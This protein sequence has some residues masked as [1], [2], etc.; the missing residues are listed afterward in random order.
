MFRGYWIAAIAFGLAFGA[1]AQEVEPPSLERNPV[2]EPRQRDSTSATENEA[3]ADV[4]QT[5]D[6]TPSLQ[7]IE[8]AIQNLITDVDQIER[9]RQQ[10]REISDLQAQLDMAF[11][12]KAMFWATTAT[13]IVTLIG[14]VLIWRTLKHTAQ[15][16]KLTGDAL[17]Q[18][19][20]QTIIARQ[21]ANFTRQSALRLE[22]PYLFIEVQSTDQLRTPAVNMTPQLSYRIVNHGKTPA[23][24]R[25]VAVNLAFEPQYPLRTPWHLNKAIHCV[26]APNGGSTQI[27]HVLVES[28]KNNDSFA[29]PIGNGLVLWGAFSYAD[30]IGSSYVDHFCIRG[31]EDAEFFHLDFEDS[32]GEMNRRFTQYRWDTTEQAEAR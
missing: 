8:R 6:I 26:I 21:S 17:K 28:A 18:A 5:I 11:W 4:P 14:V 27:F 30:A 19:E 3:A 16:E 9:Q 25:I 10:E 1:L 24:L 15:A 20:A 13:V 7:G 12:A 32:D 22:R 23:I 31:S 29:G 2:S